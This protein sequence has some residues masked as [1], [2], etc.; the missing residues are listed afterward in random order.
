MEFSIDAGLFDLFIVKHYLEDILG[1]AVD[2]GTKE[3]LREHLS[4]PVL[5]EAIRAF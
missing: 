1:C 2:L 3:A 5:K 4:S